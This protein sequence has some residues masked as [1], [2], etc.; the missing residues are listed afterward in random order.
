MEFKGKLD[1]KDGATNSKLRIRLD[2]DKA[3]IQVGGNGSGGDIEI[4]ND[5]GNTRIRL[6]AGGT[7]APVL[8]VNPGLTAA[9]E[10]I[11][12]SGEEGTIKVGG[13]GQHGHIRLRDSGSKERIHLDAEKADI[14]VGG[15]GRGGDI[16]VKD[17]ADTTK[18]LLNA[19][20]ADLDLQAGQPTIALSGASGTISAGGD[21]ADGSLVLKQQDGKTRIRLDAVGGN[22]SQPQAALRL[23]GS[24]ASIHAGGEDLVGGNIFVRSK[25]GLG[26]I[27][28]NGN[29]AEI[30]GG[31][32]ALKNEGQTRIR[33]DAQGSNVFIG[34]NGFGGNI[35]LFKS[36]GDNVN[37]SQAAIHIGGED[38]VISFRNADCAEDFQVEDAE[39]IEPGTIL[40]I[41]DDSRLQVCRDAY[42]KRV[43]GVVAGAGECR[44]GIVL[45]RK[46]EER[47]SSLP[48]A[49]MGRVYCKVDSS[50][51][52]VEVGDLLTTSP[53]PGHAMKAGDPLKAF[54]SVVGKALEPLSRG[55]GMIPIL[56]ALQ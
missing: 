34:G 26:P 30:I 21:N 13:P 18:I 42:D 47:K 27:H 38:G 52:A 3:D 54:G 46:V 9:L 15:N 43:A 48:V 1:G 7:E 36:S 32:V 17:D 56:V 49:L 28:L 53:T 51:A 41:G 11:L 55:V 35:W 50:Y 23:D 19:G 33:L 44:P 8:G 20:G 24:T 25:F 16:R 6:E 10:T 22:E 45:G 39:N 40:S 29:N 4:R 14:K 12:L 2:A 31:R 5:H 37:G